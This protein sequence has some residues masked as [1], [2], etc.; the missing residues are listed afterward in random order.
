MEEGQT[1][2]R[3]LVNSVVGAIAAVDLDVARKVES[4]VIAILPEP[5]FTF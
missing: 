3:A 1:P 5:K 2:R 4:E